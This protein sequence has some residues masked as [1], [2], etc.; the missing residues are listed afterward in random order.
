MNEINT[1]RI[2]K[3]RD[4][5]INTPYIQREEFYYYFFKKYM[6]IYRKMY[7]KNSHQ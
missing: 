5:V 4:K 7:V 2:L 6:T 3:L 1:A